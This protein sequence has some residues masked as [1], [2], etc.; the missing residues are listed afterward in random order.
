MD[1]P[2]ALPI[3]ILASCAVASVLLAGCRS[4]QTFERPFELIVLADPQ[5]GMIDENRS[6]SQEAALFARACADV[7]ARRPAFV[8]VCGDLVN[9]PGDD[10]QASELLRL[11]TSI[12]P[13]VPVRWVAGNHDVGNDP[14]SASLEWF[15]RRFGPDRCTWDHG[16][17]RFVVLDSNLLKSPGKVPAEAEAQWAWLQGRLRDAKA[18][19]L[20]VV[21]FQHH[22]LFLADPG[23][24]DQYFNIPWAE[25]R[26]HLD[27]F[28]ECGVV[29]VFAGHYHRNAMG[30]DG[31][32]EMV[33][34][35]PV[36]K[37]L[38]EDPSGYRVVTVHRDR[39]EHAYVPLSPGP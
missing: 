28:R 9:R 31:P 3:L 36:G 35:G 2:R 30:R 13:S 19:G 20:P 29:A 22:P 14:D 25:R 4:T 33:T 27:L 7:N 39:I 16:G 23:E 1:K 26:R 17:W 12:D 38:G 24:E 34:C 32:V 37:P 15:R 18:R 21:V 8:V 11:A 10:G 5:L 6:V